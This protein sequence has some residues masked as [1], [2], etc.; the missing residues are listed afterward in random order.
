LASTN[1]RTARHQTIAASV[2]AFIWYDS[3]QR[4]K[5]APLF[6]LF[7]RQSFTRWKSGFHR[8]V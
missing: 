7:S 6:K 2:R 8:V 3:F 4:R 5:I 1:P